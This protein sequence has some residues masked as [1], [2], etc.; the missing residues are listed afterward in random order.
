MLRCAFPLDL[1]GFYVLY[2]SDIYFESTS[3]SLVLQNEYQYSNT[4]CT[5]FWLIYSYSIFSIEGKATTKLHLL[6]SYKNVSE[7]RKEW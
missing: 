7:C 1:Y 4:L 3:A 5:N 6:V 2:Y